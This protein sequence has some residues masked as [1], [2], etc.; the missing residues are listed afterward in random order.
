MNETRAIISQ[1]L[2]N[3]GSSKEVDQ[4]LKQ[5]S[6]VESAKFAVIKVRGDIIR[7]DLESLCSALTFLY[8]VALY[9]IVVH[10]S[11]AQLDA[12]LAAEGVPLE[13]R[14]G[15]R[16][17]DAATLRV[18]RRVTTALN[19]DLV[20]ALERMG[21]RAR[22]IPAGVFR[23]ERIEALG[24]HGH[25]T[26]VDADP[27]R[28]AIKSGH[29]PILSCVAESDEGQLLLVHARTATLELARAVGPAK[30]I[31]LTPEGG[32][33]DDKGRLLRSFNLAEDY[34]WM[35]TQPFFSD[36]Q[37]RKFAAM[38]ALLDVLPHSSSIALTAPGLLPREL[39][40][41][42]GSGTLIRRGEKVLCHEGGL[43]DVDVPRL[44]ELLERGFG[45]QLVPDYFDK[46]GFYRVYVTE[47]YR[48]AAIL[49]MEGDLPYLDKFVVDEEAQ[50][51][52]LAGSLWERLVEDNPRLFWRSRVDNT[53]INPWYFSR[54]EGS[55]RDGR[56]VVFWYGLEGFA[57]VQDAIAKALAMPA[58]LEAAPAPEAS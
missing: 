49:T 1:L 54:A 38:K 15:R 6:E 42:R 23:A 45:R 28:A 50:G 36:S 4:Y 44:K 8:R 5:F 12:A 17:V 41:H 3:I 24:Y 39:F 11:G 33:T 2:R 52:G 53:K 57:A 34:E 7:D 47:S 40:T 27:I 21:T 26:G 58:S 48:A 46:K 19:H 31:F 16:V 51:E 25:V 13:T 56:W 37:R 20:D 14:D 32:L 30:I 18:A 55:L 22:A 9:P 29:L 35:M 10:G 43:G